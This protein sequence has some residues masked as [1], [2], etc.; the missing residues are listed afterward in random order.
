MKRQHLYRAKRK[1]GLGWA[2]GFYVENFTDE[3]SAIIEVGRG[4]VYHLVHENTVCQYIGQEDQEGKKVFE[5]DYYRTK[6]EHQEIVICIYIKEVAGFCWLS[7]GEYYNYQDNGYEA[8]EDHGVPFNCDI[9][10]T[11]SI[12]ICSNIIDKPL[13]K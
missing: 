11:N 7:E 1:H 12:K 2:K 10:D 5:Y 8:L 13:K 3:G 9:F 4:T 6:D